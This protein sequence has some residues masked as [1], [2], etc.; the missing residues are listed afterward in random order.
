[1]NQDWD[2]KPRGMECGACR[3]VFNDGQS[4]FTRLVFGQNGYERDDFCVPCWDAT[5]KSQTRYSAWQGVY[6]VPPVEPVRKVN[7]ETAESLLRG[8]IEKND[9]SRASAIYI[10]S[11]MLER[12]RVFVERETRTADDGG[13][14]IV[15]EHRKSKDTFVIRDPQLKL[16]E[17]DA[18]QHEIMDLLKGAESGADQAPDLP[19]ATGEATDPAAASAAP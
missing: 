9:P 8:L 1:M 2:I 12:Q 14:L 15:Y 5:V 16:S 18:V 13:R 7:K 19:E 10:L 17:I 4:Y 6:H 11:V 3:V